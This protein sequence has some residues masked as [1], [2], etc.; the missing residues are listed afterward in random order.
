M[1]FMEGRDT[2]STSRTDRDQHLFRAFAAALSD[3]RGQVIDIRRRD[4]LQGVQEG[5]AS[6]QQ[7][8]RQPLG[9]H[10]LIDELCTGT[11]L[12]I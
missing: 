5:E 10:Q 1:R 4:R 6:A 9:G 7:Q 11:D 12:F 8:V 2:T 3:G